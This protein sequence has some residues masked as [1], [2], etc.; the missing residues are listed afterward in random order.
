MRAWI[1]AK[2][3]NKEKALQ[4]LHTLKN[5][6]FAV[7]YHKVLLG[8]V[9]N[10]KDWV[11]QGINQIGD[12]SIPAIGYFPLLKKVIDQTGNWEMSALKKKYQDMEKTSSQLRDQ[13][14]E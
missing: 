9:L 1:Y 10:E 3:G 14:M 12:N 6:P 5:H 2:Q 7:G 4:A 11:T 13:G 8:T